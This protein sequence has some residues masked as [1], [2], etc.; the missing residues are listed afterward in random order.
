MQARRH[1]HR[2]LSHML[3]ENEYG[4][5]CPKG[6]IFLCLRGLSLA[7]YVQRTE[8]PCQGIGDSK[9]DVGE[10]ML[11]SLQAR[12]CVLQV[13]AFRVLA[14]VRVGA[15]ARLVALS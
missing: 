1:I 8:H 13:S 5:A 2:V 9:Q 10:P 7:P 6:G 11:Q 15:R 12:C 3:Y 4:I 14:R